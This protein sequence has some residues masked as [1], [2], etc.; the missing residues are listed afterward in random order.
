MRRRSSGTG[1]LKVRTVTMSQGSRYT[2][3]EM[4]RPQITSR[5]NPVIKALSRLHKRRHRDSTGRFLIEGAREVERAVAARVEIQQLLVAADYIGG[6]RAT[7]A[8]EMPPSVEIIDVGAAAFA[9][10]SRRQNPD[11]ILAVASWAPHSLDDLQ[12]PE[13]ALVLIAERIEKPGNL[14]AMLRTADGAG[15][16]GF[17]AADPATDLRN[18]NV[19]RTSQGSV[20]VVPSVV[21]TA[22][23]TAE[24]LSARNIT[25]VVIT[26]EAA[27]TIWDVDLTGPVGI[28]VGGERT[29]LSESFRVN[30]TTA[31]LPMHGIADSLNASAAAAVALYEV[32]RQRRREDAEQ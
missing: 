19:I 24:F 17:I 11:G 9:H 7:L 2:L 31:R 29:G 4:S 20:F 23:G 16:H 18:P 21:T 25:P 5:A 8:D 3:P 15:A 12:L 32:V 28:V 30:S 6:S 26:P 27:Q 22:E 13:I 10:L 14:G 1:A